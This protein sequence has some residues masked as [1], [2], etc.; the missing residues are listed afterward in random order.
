MVTLILRLM[1][2]AALARQFDMGDRNVGIS[3]VMTG[4]TRLVISVAERRLAG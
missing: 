1:D 2:V 3:M 4:V